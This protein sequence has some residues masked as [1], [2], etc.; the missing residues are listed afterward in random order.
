MAGG[1]Q[2]SLESIREGGQLGG[3][4]GGKP[5]TPVVMDGIVSAGVASVTLQ[6]PATHYRA[7][8]LAPLNAT[9]KV[10]N[11]VFVIPIPTLFQRGGWPTAA[12]WRSASGKVIKTVN[13][14]P[15]HP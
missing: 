9:G 13:E 2:Q 3:G 6:F 11:S 14:V 7:W 8:R 10:V 15:F 12:I 1:S 4:G 5:P